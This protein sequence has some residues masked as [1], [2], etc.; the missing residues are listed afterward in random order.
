MYPRNKL[1][2]GRL[3]Q[4]GM[5]LVLALIMLL[6]L[7]LLAAAGITSNNIAGHLLRNDQRRQ[8]VYQSADNII[9]FLMSNAEYFIRYPQ[10]F[11][12]AGQF[13]SE[14]PDYLEVEFLDNPR[15]NP[16]GTIH[17]RVAQGL[18]LRRLLRPVAVL[19]DLFTFEACRPGLL[20]G[21]Y[22]A[23]WMPHGHDVNMDS[24]TGR[25]VVVPEP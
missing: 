6:L 10:Y 12:S 4:R 5:V 7:G 3:C 1:M 15:G 2:L 18:W 8:V 9:N 24:A 25:G 17:H 11:D 16:D 19:H 14:L 13:S 21:A 20:L 22:R 23:A